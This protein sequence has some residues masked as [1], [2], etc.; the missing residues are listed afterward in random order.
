V[1]R[2]VLLVGPTQ[3]L[4]Q[5]FGNLMRGRLALRLTER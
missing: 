5:H 4:L 3:G 1:E 2:A